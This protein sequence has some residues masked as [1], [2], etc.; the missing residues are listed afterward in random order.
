MTK[1][2]S[3]KKENMIVIFVLIFII[4]LQFFLFNKSIFK[5]DILSNGIDIPL[6]NNGKLS[7]EKFFKIPVLDLEREV[8]I[9]LIPYFFALLINHIIGSQLFLVLLG[10]ICSF[11]IFLLCKNLLNKFIDFKLKSKTTSNYIETILSLL[12]TVLINLS[13]GYILMF[14][15]IS[16]NLILFLI[17]LLAKIYL[18]ISIYKINEKIDTDEIKDKINKKYPIVLLIYFCLLYT[19]PSP[20]DS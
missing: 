18:F 15:T 4:I 5:Q 7:L 9:S 10:S 17:T 12:F 6:I 14:Y 11:L 13:F 20:R 2:L 19:S 8:W 1:S 16:I 3:K